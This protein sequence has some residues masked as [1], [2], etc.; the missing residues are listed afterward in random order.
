MHGQLKAKFNTTAHL[1]FLE[2]V[3]FEHKEY[4]SLTELEKSVPESPELKQS[5][6]MSKN[7]K[8]SQA[9]QK[10]QQLARG[11]G[12]HIPV[13]KPLVTEFGFPKAVQQCLE[14]PEHSHLCHIDH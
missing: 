2:W 7:S 14:V 8:K 12:R 6:S 5:P 13:P 3:T 1:D 11:Q 9:K 10:D 4:V